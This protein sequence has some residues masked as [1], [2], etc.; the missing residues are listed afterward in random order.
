MVNTKG[1]KIMNQDTYHKR[2]DK[3]MRSSVSPLH[4]EFRIR[5]MVLKNRIND[6]EILKSPKE[7]AKLQGKYE[8]MKLA[9]LMAKQHY[10]YYY[11][12]LR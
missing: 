8:A 12:P 10:D 9:G 3:I 5:A 2:C 6:D 1:Y 7:I 4:A 11:E